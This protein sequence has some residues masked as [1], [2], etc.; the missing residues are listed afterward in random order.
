MGDYKQ[1]KISEGI[2][3][4]WLEGNASKDKPARTTNDT[5][6]EDSINVSVNNMVERNHSEVGLV[7]KEKKHEQTPEGNVTTFTDIKQLLESLEE[8]YNIEVYNTTSV[9]GKEE[10]VK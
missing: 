1:S 5:W 6:T 2:R 3:D 8:T 4:L 10:Y 7:N 9:K